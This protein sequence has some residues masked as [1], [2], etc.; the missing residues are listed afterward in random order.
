MGTEVK[1]RFRIQTQT[2]RFRTQNSVQGTK[3]NLICHPPA[4]NNRREGE[5]GKG[6]KGRKGRE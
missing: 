3:V 2:Q 4:R 5:E 6:W 1:S